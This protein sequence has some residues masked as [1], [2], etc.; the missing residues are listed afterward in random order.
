[1]IVSITRPRRSPLG[2]SHKGGALSSA[3]SSLLGLNANR[4]ESAVQ[5]HCEGEAVF[6]RFESG[7]QSEVVC[8][9]GP[10]D[11]V[12]ALVSLEEWIG[13]PDEGGVVRTDRDDVGAMP[14]SCFTAAA[15][16]P[17]VGRWTRNA[18][19]LSIISATVAS[20]AMAS[21]LKAWTT[22]ATASPS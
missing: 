10:V 8:P 9:I 4:P 12:A 15:S 19:P 22:S 11:V 21:G 20:A 14:T 17:L 6:G 1:M 2:A 3:A 16:S 13:R 5:R 7:D 18:P